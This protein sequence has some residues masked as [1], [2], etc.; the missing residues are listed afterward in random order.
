MAEHADVPGAAELLDRMLQDVF[1]EPHPERRSAAIA[2]IF[3]EDVVFTDPQMT[4][5]GRSELAATVSGLLAQG[6]G[7]IFSPAGDFR[8]VGNLGIRPWRL[9]PPGADPVLSGMDVVEVAD[10]RI[11]KLWTMLDS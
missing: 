9:G 3:T 1:N 11:A 7:F 8:G 5:T 10:G 2:E 6:P 4:V